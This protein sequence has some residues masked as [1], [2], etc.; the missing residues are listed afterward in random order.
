MVQCPEIVVVGAGVGGAAIAFAL[1]RGGLSVAILERSDRHIDRVRGEWLAPWGVAEAAELGLADTM[2]AAGGQYLTRS[3]FY[4]EMTE[5]GLAEGNALDLRQTHPVG[6][7]P[8]SIG[9]PAICEA[10]DEAA[11][12]RGAT[13]MRGVREIVVRAGPRPE[14]GFAH[15]DARYEW[16]PS[17]IIGADGR[18][19][20][21]RRQLGMAVLRDEPHHLIGGML[22][23]GVPDWPREQQS[24]G[25]E[26]DIHYLVFPQQGARV[27]LY[28]CY[29]FG[30]HQRFT[31][32]GREQNLLAAFRL[33]CLPLGDAIAQATP[34][35]PFHSVSNED[36]WVDSPVA[37]GVV[38]LGD[39]AGFN[40]PI[41]G[42]GLAIT[43]RDAR[44]L[45]D[46]I[47]R[48]ARKPD[49]FRPYVDE[50][51]ERMRRLRIA[52]QFAAVL[53][54]EFGPEAAERRARATRR[55]LAEGWPSPMLA[56]LTGPER[57]PSEAYAPESLAALLAPE[58]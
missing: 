19:S 55:A 51:R 22:V 44:I 28:A 2:E 37:P 33:K 56:S 53:R 40:D 38:L 39:A 11:V 9:H 30:G 10:F 48:G 50:R 46:L 18:T 17:L 57:L 8:M 47:L 41:T 14:I 6:T 5:P 4:D 27:R 13:L 15:E 49:D 36:V 45:R 7:G 29:G 20:T 35:G 16:Q 12:A 32:P 43:L 24:L 25:T 1:A 31:G 58:A 26:G 21:V 42:Q 23:D 3:I 54:V 52:A 34:I